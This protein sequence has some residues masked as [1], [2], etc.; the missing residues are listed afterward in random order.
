M[1]GEHINIIHIDVIYF[2]LPVALKVWSGGHLC[3]G[4][5]AHTTEKGVFT[6]VGIE[7]CSNF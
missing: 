1:S 7:T 5:H 6:K 3:V 4:A 2:P